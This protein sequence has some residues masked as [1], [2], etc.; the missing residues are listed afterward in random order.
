[1]GVVVY[2]RGVRLIVR[3]INLHLDFCTITYV[4]AFIVKLTIRRKFEC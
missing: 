4:T 2:T 3:D 1:M